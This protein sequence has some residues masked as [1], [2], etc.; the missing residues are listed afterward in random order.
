M[1]ISFLILEEEM[2]KSLISMICNDLANIRGNLW[3]YIFYL[4]VNM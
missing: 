2:Q 3:Y 4:V 1:N